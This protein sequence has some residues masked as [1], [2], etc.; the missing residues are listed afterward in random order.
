M[1]M[2]SGMGGGRIAFNLDANEES[3]FV[4]WDSVVNAVRRAGTQ[5]GSQSASQPGSH[6]TWCQAYHC[7]AELY[8]N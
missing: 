8:V 1:M 5:P 4:Y 6:F 3:S 2:A 7:R